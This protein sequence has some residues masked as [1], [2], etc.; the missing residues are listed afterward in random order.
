MD[1]GL[2]KE[3]E[4]SFSCTKIP[5]SDKDICDLVD[6][7]SEGIRAAFLGERWNELELVT[8]L[9][10]G[11]DALTQLNDEAY[12]YYLPSY[13]LRLVQ[14]I[15]ECDSD[16]LEL[17]VSEFSSTVNYKYTISRLTLFS[18]QQI[19]VVYKVLKS[20]KADFIKSDLDSAIKLLKKT[21][22]KDSVLD[23]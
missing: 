11:G 2:I 15:D 23:T 12:V 7:G 6:P 1:N 22:K 16:I 4:D 14:Q 3:I 20:A 19:S 9:N 21:V 18:K 13:L 8:L 17:I 10:L 5:E